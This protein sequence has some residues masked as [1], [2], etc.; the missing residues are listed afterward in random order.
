MKEEVCV[1]LGS[2]LIKNN[3]KHFCRSKKARKQLQTMNVHRNKRSAI[4]KLELKLVCVRERKKS[5]G[6][7]RHI[8]ETETRKGSN[9]N[10]M[11]PFK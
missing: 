11:K 3:V 8:C 6:L 9:T 10:G 4:D 1:S 2:V 7:W 5:R